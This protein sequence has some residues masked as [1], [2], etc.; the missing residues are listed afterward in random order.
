ML[1][2]FPAIL[3]QERPDPQGDASQITSVQF[4][5]PDGKRVVKKFLKSDPVRCLFQHIKAV[6]VDL[7][8]KSFDVCFLIF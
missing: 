6:A 3:P 8:S 1:T 4:R 7:Q 5:L 2:S